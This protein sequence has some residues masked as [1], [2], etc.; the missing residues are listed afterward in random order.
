MAQV[1][2]T[3]KIKIKASAKP[4]LSSSI[5]TGT[6]NQSVSQGSLL[7]VNDARLHDFTHRSTTVRNCIVEVLAFYQRK[8]SAW[9]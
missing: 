7:E 4:Y 2:V 9:L 3:I 1:D 5:S 6:S 8:K